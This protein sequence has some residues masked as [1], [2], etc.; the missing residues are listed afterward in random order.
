MQAQIKQRVV[1]TSGVAELFRITGELRDRPE[2]LAALIAHSHRDPLKMMDVADV[3]LVLVV[4]LAASA[5]V[6]LFVGLLARDRVGMLTVVSLAPLII[7]I[8][9]QRRWQAYLSGGMSLAAA[10]WLSSV[11]G[12]WQRQRLRRSTASG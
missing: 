11:S 8:I 1:V 7:L 5:F 10:L 2:A 9:L 12:R 3:L 6:G 4:P